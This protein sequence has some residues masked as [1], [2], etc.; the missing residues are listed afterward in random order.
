MAHPVLL[1]DLLKRIALISGLPPVFGNGNNRSQEPVFWF[2]EVH[3]VEI[4]VSGQDFSGLV[5]TGVPVNMLVGL[6]P[7]GLYT[8]LFASMLPCLRGQP[9]SNCRQK[10]P[11]F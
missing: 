4:L 10:P 5:V 1:R 9:I 11:Y 6:Y 2:Q 3:V 7:F 8:E